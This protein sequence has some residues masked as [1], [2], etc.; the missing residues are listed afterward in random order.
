MRRFLLKQLIFWLVL[1][2]VPGTIYSIGILPTGK[3]EYEFIYDRLERVDA[4]TLD[5]YDY[6]L[7][8][9][10]LRNRNFSF[11]P[12][13]SFGDIP[14]GR[15]GLFGF[16]GEDFRAARENRGRGFESIRGGIVGQP[17]DKFFV[18]GSFLLDEEK[19]RDE[20]YTG[21]KW[22][23]LAGY[24]QDAFVYYHSRRF[25]L[26][27][28]RFA[29]FWGPRNSLV[30]CGNQRMDGFG[31]TFHWG[32]LA[33]S[34][35]LARL[36]GLH[37]D[38]DGVLQFEN[39]YFAGHRVDFHLNKHLR[40]GLFE[41]VVFGG[42]GRQI[43][44]FYLNPLIFFHGSQLNEGTNDNTTV[45]FD[46]SIKPAVGYKFYGQLLVDDIQVDD[47]SQD[48]QEPAEVAF[49]LGGYVVNLA[50]WFDLKAE[51]SR[52]TNWT[53]N[54]IY[55]RNRYIFDSR[56]IGRVL[57]NDYDLASL[58]LI[59]W[60]GDNTAAVFRFDHYRQG[61]G[62][63]DAEWTEPWKQVE[64]DYSEPFPTGTV[65]KTT[66]MTLGIKSFI[67]NMAFVDVEAG[68]DLVKNQNHVDADD[69]TLPFINLKISSF[70]LTSVKLE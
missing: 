7:G 29:S 55:P 61:E 22:R 33:L 54:Q 26:I 41:T 28:G 66:R 40:F 1:P 56:P 46:F 34:Y 12:F 70:F 39:R 67:A 13:E 5:Y 2:A 45:G 63:I 69:R 19:A 53:F 9:Y 38:A 35:R 18:Y 64:G 31:Y 15:L 36:D 42:P 16:A 3:M 37:P 62:R 30:L 50:G 44:L 4:L 47:Q 10:Q 58:S 68:I 52:V 49:L 65:Q 24:V 23:G 21:K 11:G 60:M 32:K 57:G 43:D 51:Y 25:E 27:V 8:P 17:H 20:N 48:D 14:G 6:Q 59:R